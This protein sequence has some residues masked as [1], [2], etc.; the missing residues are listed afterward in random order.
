MNITRSVLFE[1]TRIKN[2]ELRNR[3]VRSATYD[4]CAEDGFV[5]DKQLNLYSTLSEGGVGLII[6]GITYVHESSEFSK[7]QNSIAGDKFI[8]GTRKLSKRKKL[9]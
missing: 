7:L 4:G 8:D 5:T 3:F 2:M 6:T 1:P 9:I